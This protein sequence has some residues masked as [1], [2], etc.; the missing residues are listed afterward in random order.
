MG[1]GLPLM[2]ALTVSQ[3]R[4][5]LAHEFGHFHGGD[6]RLGPWIYKTRGA[7]ER[8]LVSLHHRN[9]L[10]SRPFLW[11]GRTFVRITHAV[12][13]RQEFTA[14]A[15]AAR[16]VGARPLAD[17][18]RALPGASWAFDA[19]WSEEL[20]PVLS[21]GFHPPVAD[22]FRRFRSAPRIS[23]ASGEATEQALAN[24]AA[25]PYDTHPS[26]RERVA[27]V[28]GLPAGAAPAN[29]PPALTLLDR[30]DLLETRLLRFLGGPKAPPLQ[31]AAWEDLAEQA[32]LPFWRERHAAYAAELAGLTPADL[33]GYAADLSPLAVRLGIVTDPSRAGAAEARQVAWVIGTALTVMLKDHGWQLSALPGE[34][35]VLRNG[36]DEVRPFSLLHDVDTGKLP[37]TEWLALC[38][39]YRFAGADLGRAAASRDGS[40]QAP[41]RPAWSFVALEYHGMVLNRTYR[42]IVT[43]T[44]LCGAK[45]RGIMS[46]PISVTEAWKDPEFYPKPKLQARYAGIDPVSAEFL[47]VDQANFRIAHQELESVEL[48]RKPKWGMGGVPYSGRVLLNL[49]NGRTR[50]LVLLGHQDGEAIVERLRRYTSEVPAERVS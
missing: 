15:L 1:L 39:R 38:V 5:V 35:V 46:A 24:E 3:F 13:R 47:A 23:A 2:E 29:D 36:D 9:S 22:G 19:Y 43:E 18:L 33:P 27:A 4:A 21:L 34:D 37:G 16:I 12:S 32:W 11:Y 48:S 40:V 30:P 14:D 7:I 10:V 31:P 41:R 8:T 42:V 20:A 17:G 6:T 45:V 44:A 26:L 50:D 49:R 28:E 25:D